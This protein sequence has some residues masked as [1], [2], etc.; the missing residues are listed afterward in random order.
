MQFA[1]LS[2]PAMW[3]PGV[4]SPAFQSSFSEFGECQR[5]GKR[6]AFGPSWQRPGRGSACKLA[7]RLSRWWKASCFALTPGFRRFLTFAARVPEDQAS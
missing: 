5:W 1:G 7:A 3:I 4:P 2:L 6:R